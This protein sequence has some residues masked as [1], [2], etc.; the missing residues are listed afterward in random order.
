LN[1]Q[2]K[3]RTP[4]PLAAGQGMSWGNPNQGLSEK[5]KMVRYWEFKRVDHI[6]IVKVWREKDC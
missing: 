3:K 2:G 5:K 4:P 1:R 6:E